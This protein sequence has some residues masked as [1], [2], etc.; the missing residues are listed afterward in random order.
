MGVFISS[1]GQKATKYRHVWFF[2]QPLLR[3]YKLA[4]ISSR[5]IHTCLKN[6]ND[7]LQVPPKRHMQVH[8]SII[9]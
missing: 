8:L 9:D 7:T 2:N 6:T 3:K 4:V 5:N 1:D